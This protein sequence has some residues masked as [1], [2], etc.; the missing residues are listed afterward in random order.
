MSPAESQFEY[1]SQMANWQHVLAAAVSSDNSA[2][3]GLWHSWLNIFDGDFRLIQDFDPISSLINC[4]LKRGI[5]IH[6]YHTNPV[7]SRWARLR[8]FGSGTGHEIDHLMIAGN[9][10]QDDAADIN[11]LISRWLA[12]PL[13]DQPSRDELV[14]QFSRLR[15]QV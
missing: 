6:I 4:V 15:G 13:E 10:T 12:I 1:I 7:G 14:S 3:T 2:A 11:R 5:S 8:E 9:L